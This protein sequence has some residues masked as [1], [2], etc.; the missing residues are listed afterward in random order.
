MNSGERTVDKAGDVSSAFTV[1]AFLFA[2]AQLF[3]YSAAVATIFDF[4]TNYYDIDYCFTVAICLTAVWVILNP[5]SLYRSIFLFVFV[6]VGTI[7]RMPIS[8]NHVVFE[9][10]V[11]ISILTC[12]VYMKLKEKSSFTKTKFYEAFAPVVRLEVIV[13]Y[14][15]AAI[16][17]INTGFFDKDISCATIQLF[18]VKDVLPIMPTPDWFIS[19]NPFLTL[20]TESS[21]PIL[22]II[23]K[24][25]ILGLIIAIIFHFI[26]GF[27]YTGFTILVYSFLSLFIPA[28]SYDRIKPNF[29]QLTYKLSKILSKFSNY[30]DWKKTRFDNFITQLIFLISIFF[31][32]GFFMRGNPEKFYLLS[33]EGLYIIFFFVFL[34]AFFYFVIR[35]VKEFRIEQRI[36]L[37]PEMKWL[38]IFPILVLVNGSLPHLGVKNIQSMA[39]FSNLR[40][41]GGKTNHLFIPSFFQSSNNLEDLV[42]IKGANLRELNKFSGFSSRRPL[43]GTSVTLPRSYVKHMENNDKDYRERFEYKV[44]FVLLQNLVTG[45]AK[46]G[47]KDI[48]LEYERDGEILYTRNAEVDPVLSKASIFQRKFI[49]QR[50]VPDDDRGLCMW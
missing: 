8:P 48:K 34:I 27:V 42:T 37:V 6:I 47:Q 38:L 30:K 36:T 31:L 50:A 41:E 24:T 7:I 26:L 45:L 44:P 5:S 22:L 40:T 32:M 15:W 1:F 19:I 12:F 11:L 17:K 46:E 43:R 4:S 18:N 10:I 3:D 21:I 13:L 35:G 49:S 2:W 14:F 16:H 29:K 23:P 28:S 25:R 20:L 33:E 39:M 9:V